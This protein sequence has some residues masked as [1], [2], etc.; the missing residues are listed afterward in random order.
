[1]E[2]FRGD[3][4]L[5]WLLAAAEVARLG[6]FRPKQFLVVCLFSFLLSYFFFPYFDRLLLY[7]LIPVPFY[8]HMGKWG[9]DIPYCST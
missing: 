1:M 3:L 5:A 4:L 9:I 6:G 7:G 8:S 2:A